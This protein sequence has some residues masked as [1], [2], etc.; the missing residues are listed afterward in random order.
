MP[1]KGF[2]RA[3]LAQ[4]QEIKKSQLDTTPQDKIHTDTL[5]HLKEWGKVTKKISL[6]ICH[7]R[8]VVH[9]LDYEVSKP[10]DND[11]VYVRQGLCVV[12]PT[13]N[14]VSNMKHV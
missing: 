11:V 10:V 13:K 6:Y 8:N 12:P 5:D 7:C 2:T 3:K 4:L 1:G 9:D 14:I